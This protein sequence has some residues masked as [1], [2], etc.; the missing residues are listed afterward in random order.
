MPEFIPEHVPAYAT[1]FLK[2][3]FEAAEW[4]WGEDID[5]DKVTRGWTRA[6]RSK[7]ERDCKKFQKENAR[8]LQ[9]YVLCCKHNRDHDIGELAGRDFFLSRNGHGAGFFDR[10]DDPV[11]DQLQKA[12]KA[13]GQTDFYYDRGWMK[14]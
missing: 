9:L 7:M 14:L 3:Y 8:D 6:T 1:G 11:F 10:G 13:Y 2:G 12:A 4:L 5:R